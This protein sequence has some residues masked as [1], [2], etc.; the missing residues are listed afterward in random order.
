MTECKFLVLC[1]GFADLLQEVF[2]LQYDQDPCCNRSVVT[3]T[4]IETHQLQF[5]KFYQCLHQIL[6]VQI[7]SQFFLEFVAHKSP[8]MHTGLW[9]GTRLVVQ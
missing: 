7:A 1:L 4:L 2:S 5:G 9:A 8:R 6:P 3:K